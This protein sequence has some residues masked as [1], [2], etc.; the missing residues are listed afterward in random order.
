MKL[1]PGWMTPA[2]LAVPLFAV[3][4]ADDL[5]L[6]T[7]F[8]ANPRVRAATIV[9]GQLV[10]IGA[11]TLASI[12]IARLAVQLPQDWIPF[13]GL[14][15]V[16]LGIRQLLSRDEDDNELKAPKLN[17][18]VI[19]TITIAN[20]GDNLGVYIPVFA[21][22]SMVGTVI[23]SAMFA[24]LTFAWCGLA[25]GMVR[26]PRWGHRIS[27][28]AGTAAPYVFIAVGVWI[29]AKHAAIQAVFG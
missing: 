26:H 4:N 8:F 15:P 6:L 17:W 18:W 14:V 10:G 29:L 7:I 28:I 25:A 20:G 21:A 13:L 23:I 9:I 11:L 24:I 5:V 2:L 12:L 19:A 27:S 22:Q 16:A 3:T 1:N